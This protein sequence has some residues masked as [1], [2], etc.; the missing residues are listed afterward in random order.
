M[1]HDG[2]SFIDIE[3]FGIAIWHRY[4]AFYLDSTLQLGYPPLFIL[5]WRFIDLCPYSGTYTI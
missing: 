3:R 4:L 2:Y 5:L 1:A